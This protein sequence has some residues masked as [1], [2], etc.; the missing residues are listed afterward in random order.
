MYAQGKKNILEKSTYTCS[1]K[2]S[3]SIKHYRGGGRRKTNRLRLT[4]HVTCT[5]ATANTYNISWTGNPKEND[6]FA[7]LDIVS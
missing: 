3:L 2:I 4:G 1:H 5:M 6:H 7:N